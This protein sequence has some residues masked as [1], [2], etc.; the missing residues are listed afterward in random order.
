M[1]FI[2]I[3]KKAKRLFFRVKNVETYCWH[4]IMVGQ[5]CR[6]GGTRGT[7]RGRSTTVQTQAKGKQIN[8]VAISSNIKYMLLINLIDVVL[9]YPFFAHFIPPFTFFLQIRWRLVITDEM[10]GEG[11]GPITTASAIPLKKP[12]WGQTIILIC[13]SPCTEL[14]ILLLITNYLFF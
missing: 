7:T 11:H 14:F 1:I 2:R 6:A 12:C 4:C 10:L 5:Q 8:L 13:I 3:A 9:I